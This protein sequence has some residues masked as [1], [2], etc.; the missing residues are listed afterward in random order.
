MKK[1]LIGLAVIVVLLGG[2]VLLLPQ[3]IPQ[4]AVRD[5]LAAV[6]EAQTGRRLTIGG[7]VGVAL[8]PALSVQID[9]VTLANAPGGSAPGLVTLGRLNVEVALMPLLSGEVRIEKLVLDHP[10]VA[11]EVDAGGNPNWTLAPTGAPAGDGGEDGGGLALAVRQV[12]IV[13]G[14][15]SYADASSGSAPV[16]VGNID[17][18]ASLTEGTGTLEVQ[19]SAERG[20]Q[21]FRLH[22]TTPDP[23]VFLTSAAGDVDLRIEGPAVTLGYSGE[24][25]AAGA[26]GALSLVVPSGTGLAALLGLDPASVPVGSLAL[27]T[28]IDASAERVA[29][30]GIVLDGT[31]V[32]GAQG[33]DAHVTGDLVLDLGAPRPRLS[34]ELFLG[35]LRLPAGGGGA[36]GGGFD[37][38]LLG[39]ADADLTL[40]ADALQWGDL[41]AS[42]VELRALLADGTLTLDAGRF[43]AFG[44]SAGVQAE[45]SGSAGALSLQANAALNDLRIDQ[46]LAAAGGPGVVSG[47]LGGAA[48]IAG[49]GADLTGVISALRISGNFTVGGGTVQ[50]PGGEAITGLD[51]AIALPSLDGPVTVTGGAVLRGQPL[52]TRLVVGNPLGLAAGGVGA[53]D[54][55]LQG[56][57][58]SLA[59]QGQGGLAPNLQLAGTLAFQADEL[60]AAA[61]IAG[62]DAGA[63]PPGP[64]AI[65]GEIAMSGD[66]ISLHRGR[67]TLAGT[68]ASGDLDIAGFGSHPVVTGLLSADRI[69]LDRLAGAGGSGGSGALDLGF[70]R[71]F[72][73]DLTLDTGTVAFSG[74]ELTAAPVVARVAGGRAD[75]QIS[76]AGLSGGRLTAG[77]GADGSGAV[78]AVSADVRLDGASASAL[79][80]Q[81]A[82]FDRL[83]GTLNANLQVAGAGGTTAA[84]LRSLDG[85]GAW[86][87]SDGAIRGV[88][89]ASM[90]R[91]LRA[92][93]T[94]AAGGDTP[95]AELAGHFAL[96]DGLMQVDQLS[97]LS[98]LFRVDGA[99]RIDL[100]TQ[101]V[102]LK[103]VPR[104]LASEDGASGL[105]VPVLVSGTLSNLSFAPDLQD[106]VAG[107]LQ[108]PAAAR[109][110]LQ[111]LIGQAAQIRDTLGTLDAGAGLAAVLQNLNTAGALP[112]QLPPSLLQG[113]TGT[114]GAAEPAALG[115]VET[116]PADE[117][118]PPAEEPPMDSAPMTL[119]PTADTDV[120]VSTPTEIPVPEPA[121]VPVIEPPEQPPAPPTEEPPAPERQ[122]DELPPPDQPDETPPPDETPV[123]EP[124]A[125]PDQPPP[126]TDLA[127]E[128][129]PAAPA[130][131][132][133]APAELDASPADA[134]PAPD[135]APAEPEAAPADLEP[136]VPEPAAE[137]PPQPAAEPAP[138][139]AAVIEAPPVEEPP[140]PAPAPAPQPATPG[141]WAVDPATG[142]LVE[143]GSG[144]LY[145]PVSRGFFEPGTLAP[146]DPAAAPA[147]P[148]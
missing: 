25:G 61:P 97:L 119:A 28:A 71:R 24:A 100:P 26:T 114:T 56:A 123:E 84:L 4:E 35:S 101:A 145:D 102:A 9:D 34:G 139:P 117:A 128:L 42:G 104:L 82:G 33:G 15:V 6:I 131:A 64:A 141:G 74:L 40:H 80:G 81:L 20:G 146:V 2:A 5:R 138:P 47:R 7:N 75:L 72:D 69:D 143:P 118:A 54:V 50:M 107:V 48:Q 137:A 44:G 36:G 29:L 96:T 79:L 18:V 142:Y 60:A 32:G 13:D 135:A 130:E 70:L 22:A 115:A 87:V 124:P 148:G 99:G 27:D 90:V 77:I 19:G 39:I 23:M 66:R 144:L 134:E 12:E 30:A 86:A 136:V 16:T 62:L 8:F 110:Q 147:P 11:L 76:G 65:A 17:L 55:A 113:L 38:A 112:I 93:F 122:P 57:G 21:A 121:D 46:V 73:L 108:D 88:D 129:Q 45:L 103:L 127:P 95:F 111:S 78:P 125:V 51:L 83:A 49:A 43:G 14:V 37:P 10:T 3:L 89:L 41:A 91:N 116:A 126:P 52:Q 53:L 94:G 140:P 59:F 63:V 31:A 58:L 105:A 109:Q 106:M 92:A 68:N 85:E 67:F 98:Q 133:P 1:L 132:E 120:P